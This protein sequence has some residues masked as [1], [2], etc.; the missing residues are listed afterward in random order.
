MKL[1]IEVEAS[2][3]I[4]GQSTLIEGFPGEL[5]GN[6]GLVLS[7]TAIARDPRHFEWPANY[8]RR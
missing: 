6:Q 3:L 8:M 7:R 2:M 5:W 4:F 1:I